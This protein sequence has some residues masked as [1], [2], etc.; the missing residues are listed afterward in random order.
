M[1][2]PLAALALLSLAWQPVAFAETL[3]YSTGF[4]APAFAAGPI[5]GG[6]YDQPQW[7]AANG[8]SATPNAPYTTDPSPWAVVSGSKPASGS[9]SLRLS[10]DPNTNPQIGVTKR[11]TPDTVALNGGPGRF[12]L[13]MQL[14][15]DQATTADTRWTVGLTTG[16]GLNV[17]MTLLPDNRVMF[18]HYLMNVAAF[19]TPGFDLHNTWLTLGIE[20]D[21]AE[22]SALL[23]SLSGRGQTWQQQVSSPGGTMPM[24]YLNGNW[25]TFPNYTG[26]VVY[27]DDFRV[28]YDLAPVPEPGP[29]ALLLGGM[30]GL[31]GWRRR[32]A[33]RG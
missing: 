5:G 32:G 2:K 14:Y 24:V 8:W 18:G 31:L 16:N 7:T 29:W 17:G 3:L 12:G 23:I 26:A 1:P 21:P 30:A 25:P 27:V 6:Y 19:F 20:R 13:S 10:I 9:Q 4:E 33:L 15:I 11:F 28:G 22:A